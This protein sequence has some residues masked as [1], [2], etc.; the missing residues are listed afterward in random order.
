MNYLMS[1]QSLKDTFNSLSTEVLINDVPHQAVITMAHL[2]MQSKRY[3]HSFIHSFIQGDYVV[4]NEGT[5]LVV[6]DVV[7]P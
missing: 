1:T 4:F 5:Y 2:G 6:E 3:I 7:N